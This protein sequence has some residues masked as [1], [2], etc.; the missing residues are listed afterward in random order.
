VKGRKR[1]MVVDTQGADVDG[2]SAL[3]RRSGRQAPEKYC[4]SCEAGSH[5]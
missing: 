4:R 3:L 2:R 5:G 1:H